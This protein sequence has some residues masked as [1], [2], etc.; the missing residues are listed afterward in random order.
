MLQW[1]NRDHQ[2][3]R[4]TDCR[5][6]AVVQVSVRLFQPYVGCDWSVAWSTSLNG[7]IHVS[8]SRSALSPLAQLSRL[9]LCFYGARQAVD[10]LFQVDAFG[11]GRCDQRANSSGPPLLR[12]SLKVKRNSAHS[13]SSAFAESRAQGYRGR[14]ACRVLNRRSQ[15]GRSPLHRFGLSDHLVDVIAIDALKQAH[16]ESGVGGLDARQ[17]HWSQTFG[18]TM[19]LYRY[20]AYVE[21]DC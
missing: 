5:N 9:F 19:G 3:S 10:G 7:P 12:P 18:T 2:R 11:R 16:L 17:D 1:S 14:G 8:A 6:R 15:P 13:Q 20:A 4:W 21:Q